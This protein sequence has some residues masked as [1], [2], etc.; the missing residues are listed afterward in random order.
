MTN[1][2]QA[3]ELAHKIATT[4]S[5]SIDLILQELDL[6]H[7]Q[8]RK[9][10]PETQITPALALDILDARDVDGFNIKEIKRIWNL[11]ESQLHYAL[12]N[13]NA[14]IPKVDTK[15]LPRSDIERALRNSNGSRSQTDIAEE[16]GVSQSY[17][18]KVAKELNLLPSRKK[19]VALTEAQWEDI[20]INTNNKSIEQLAKQYG[21]SRDTI[22]KGL[23]SKS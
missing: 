23:R 17:V 14:I 1:K 16:F 9:R 20:K 2:Y 18:H 4:T 15:S 10:Y 19:R 21:V 8:Y 12:Y 3:I 5:L 22:Y 7:A 11:S 13:P 6:S